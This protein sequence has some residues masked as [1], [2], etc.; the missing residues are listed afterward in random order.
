[1]V[2]LDLRIRRFTPPAQKLL[3]LL[4]FDVG[5]RLG[6]IRTN[7]E[8]HDLEALVQEAIHSASPQ[9]HEVREKNGAWYALRIRPYK[10]WDSKITGAV[11]SL[12]DI[13]TLKRRLDE[14]R[15]YADDLIEDSQGCI[16]VLDEQLRVT[17]A[18]RAFFRTFEVTATETEGRSIYGL[19][20]GEWDLPE[21]RRVLEEIIPS[22]AQ[23]KDYEVRRSFA[24]LGPR[25]MVLN[26]RRGELR[27][28]R[29]SIV[30]TMEDVTDRREQGAA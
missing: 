2:S 1:M 19:G 18:N 28:G 25:T 13:D 12:Q 20:N 15:E 3:N 4:P 30:L 21:L 22:N 29:P 14:T 5:R 26:A 7:L 27:S 9:E 17:A 24:K 23:A 6:E 8:L 16:L 10:S 11:I